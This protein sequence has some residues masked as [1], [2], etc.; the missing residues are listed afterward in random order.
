MYYGKQG[1]VWNIQANQPSWMVRKILQT[2]KVL[3]DVGWN[4]SQVIQMEKF[5]IKQVYQLMRGEYPK[6]EWRKLICNTCTCPKWSFILFLTLHGR[7]LMKAR[8]LTWGSVENSKC[9]LCDD[10]HEDID[11]L[12]FNCHYSS[13]VWQQILRWQNIQKQATGWTEEQ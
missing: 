10:G 5:S 11:H 13:K 7:L 3:E 1:T 4:E 8:L 2:H 6:V 12:F 9:I